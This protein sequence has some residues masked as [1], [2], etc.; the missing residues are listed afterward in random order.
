MELSVNQLCDRYN[1]K[2]RKTLYNRL[3]GL[4][5]KLSKKNNKSFANTE[6]IE[7]L[8]Q[9]D[10]HI[11]NGGTIDNFEPVEIAEVTVHNSGTQH[12]EN[13]DIS[14]FESTTQLT[15]Q[16][17]TQEELLGDIATAVTMAIADKLP[18]KNPLWYMHELEIAMA[19]NWQLSTSQ[20][21]EM[22]G[23]K[24]RGETFK[25]GCFI[26]S[27]CGKIN[28]ESAWRVSKETDNNSSKL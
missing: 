20:I 28:R 13:L 6:Q 26:F 25:H 5:I 9:Q 18:P 21:K 19:S 11:R 22:I 1:I 24:P 7:L 12:S 3:D 8:D 23:V 27:K 16:H 4:N 17:E 2:S 15:A 14:S 10:K